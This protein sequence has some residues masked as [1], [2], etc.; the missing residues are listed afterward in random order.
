MI[1][2][3]TQNPHNQWGQADFPHC[4]P[5]GLVPPR[6]SHDTTH[7][8]GPLIPQPDND[9]VHQERGEVVPRL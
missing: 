9:V 6:Q 4:Q 1:G 2:P 7:Q 5:G 3:S 8:P